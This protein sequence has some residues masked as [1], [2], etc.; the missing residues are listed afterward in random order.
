MNSEAATAKIVPKLRYAHSA[1]RRPGNFK[2]L[3]P[4]IAENQRQ[5]TCM[6]RDVS[7]RAKGSSGNDLQFEKGSGPKLQYKQNRW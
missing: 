1:N 3:K 5:I 2:L 6:P 4:S 7:K